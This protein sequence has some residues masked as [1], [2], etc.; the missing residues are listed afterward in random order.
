[1]LIIDLPNPCKNVIPFLFADDLTLV[2]LI[3]GSQNFRNKFDSIIER[4]LE[5]NMPFNVVKSTH[6]KFGKKGHSLNF[7]R[8]KSNMPT[9][10]TIYG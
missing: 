2:S 6:L 1:M 8:M 4:N 3:R 5:R 7:D 9:A 10:K